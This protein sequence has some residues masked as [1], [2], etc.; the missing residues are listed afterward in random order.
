MMNLR[1]GAHGVQ[2][3]IVKQG[4]APGTMVAI[5]ALLLLAVWIPTNSIFA[6]PGGSPAPNACLVTPNPVTAG[7]RYT[8]QGTGLASDY[9]VSVW[10]TTMY[11]DFRSPTNTD[12]SGN[13]AYAD[14]ALLGGH[15]KVEV[16]DANQK[17]L[18]A[19]RTILATCEFDAK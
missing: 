3:P 15:Y 9:S 19:T 4:H 8:V 6:A 12:G 2:D 5:L 18:K 17:T 13:L 11:G 16:H 7:Q 14:Y 1:Q 10:V